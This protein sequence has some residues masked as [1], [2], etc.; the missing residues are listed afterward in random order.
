MEVDAVGREMGEIEGYNNRRAIPGNDLRLTIDSKLQA[1]LEE[2]MK[3]YVLDFFASCAI[4]PPAILCFLDCVY[5]GL[6]V[7][8]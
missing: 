3:N 7:P 1:L 8:P 5:V 4:P 2:E 6:A